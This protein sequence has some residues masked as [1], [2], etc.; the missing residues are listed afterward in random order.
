MTGHHTFVCYAR[1]NGDFVHALAADIRARGLPLWLDT[2]IVPGEDWDRAIDDHLRTCGRFLVVLSPAAVASTEVRGELRLA[3]T[4]GKLILPVLYEPCSIPRQLQNLQYLDFSTGSDRAGGYDSIAALLTSPPHAEARTPRGDVRPGRAL[5]NRHDYLDDA[6]NEIVG[7]LAQSLN[8]GTLNVMK[9][10][11]PDRVVR[12]W[13]AEVRI[14][15]HQRTLLSG[16]TSII[17]LFDDPAVRGRLLILGAPGSGKTTALLELAREL[18]ARAEVDDA[19]PMPVLCNLSSWRGDGDSLAAWLVDQLKIKYGVRKDNGLEWLHDRMIVPLLDGVDEVAPDYQE[20]CLEAIH[21]FQDDNRPPSLVVSCRD[22]EYENYRVTLQLNDAV[23]LLPLADEQ[24]RD[25]LTR[26]GF[27]ELWHG[28]GADPES[29]GLARSPLLLRIMTVA[30]AE[31]KP[32]EWQRLTSVSERQSRLF[33][34]YVRRLLSHTAAERYT[35]EQTLRWLAWLARTMKERGQAEFLLEQLQPTWLP[36]TGHRWLYRIGVAA[37]CV[38]LVGV[39]VLLVGSL[40][41]LVPDGPI[42]SR[43]ATMM[44]DSGLPQDRYYGLLVAIVG[45]ASGVIIA[46]RNRIQPVETLVWSRRRAWRRMMDG[47]ADLGLL[48]SN[49]IA[50]VGLIAALVASVTFVASDRTAPELAVWARVGYGA[51]V[52]SLL[53]LA[54]MCALTLTPG[55]WLTGKRGTWSRRGSLEGLLS[56]LTFGLVA[57]ANMGVPIGAASGGALALVHG[58]RGGSTGLSA[59]VFAR[60]LVIGILSGLGI[61]AITWWTMGLRIGVMQWIM[62]WIVGGTG[63]AACV[64][65]YT[66]AASRL[67]VG[68]VPR[69]SRAVGRLAAWQWHAWLLAGGILAVVLGSV[70]GGLGRLDGTLVRGLTVMTTTVGT[71]WTAA[72]AFAFL[73]VSMSAAVGMIMGGFLGALYGVLG[74]LTGPEILRRMRP[75]QGIWQSAGNIGIFAAIGGL[76]IGL[77]YGVWNLTTGAIITRTFPGATDYVRLALMPALLF[78]VLS[79]LVPAAACI[80]HA[81]LRSVLS[82]GGLAPWRYARFLDYATDRLF[83]QRVGGR[84]RFIHDL[85]R[86]H[87]A[88]MR[89]LSATSSTAVDLLPVQ[90]TKP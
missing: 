41:E 33:D 38:V 78:A 76:V 88:G 53:S 55:N 85:L 36:T 51:A 75:N 87:L 59:I 73:L 12:P 43:Y 82:S 5:R 65:L 28:L 3:L 7:R 67:L 22:A 54:V 1:E 25:Y 39:A 24:I 31:A 69:L 80:Q 63:I 58:V 21:R 79:G 57:I 77:P 14:A 50:Y 84:Y 29:I 52:V 30:Y 16:D 68:R 56:G 27:A 61:G 20:R 4:L 18:V 42:I 48:W 9:E 70:L 64:A 44:R 23:R 46:G 86:D 15:N 17:D 66:D 40:A 83:L 8:P 89:P 72:L 11:C 90:W 2:D 60:A 47:L 74:G 13:D 32:A 19:E 35:N 81:V 45:V 62:L 71:A 34:V 49:R 37:A 26:A 6:K 10:R